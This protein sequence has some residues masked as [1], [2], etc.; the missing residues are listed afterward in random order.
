M[1]AV[2]LKL[3]IDCWVQGMK[4]DDAPLLFFQEFLERM[5]SFYLQNLPPCASLSL[6]LG[7]MILLF[8]VGLS[9][10][11]VNLTHSRIYNFQ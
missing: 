1:N 2:D 7:S 5:F 6:D 10:L 9:N 8:L 11:L 3:E 4:R